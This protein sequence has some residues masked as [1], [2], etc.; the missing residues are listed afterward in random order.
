MLYYLCHVKAAY[1]GDKMLDKN[2]DLQW[3][4]CGTQTLFV[5]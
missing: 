3:N 5:K 4:Q 2:P 1:L